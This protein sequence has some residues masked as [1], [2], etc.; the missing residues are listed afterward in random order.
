MFSVNFISIN[1][2]RT[3]SLGSHPLQV[4]FHPWQRCKQCGGVACWKIRSRTAWEPHGV[5]FVFGKKLGFGMFWDVLGPQ[6]LLSLSIIFG[7]PTVSFIFRRHVILRQEG[8]PLDNS[9][10]RLTDSRL[11]YGQEPRTLQAPLLGRSCWILLHQK[12]LTDHILPAQICTSAQTHKLCKSEVWTM[13]PDSVSSRF[14]SSCCDG[15]LR[16]LHVCFGK[17]DGSGTISST[18]ALARLAS[19]ADL[20]LWPLG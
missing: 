18:L 17:G 12:N 11:C 20:C 1:P 19:H 13:A 4:R 2:N 9:C 16:I 5:P 6:N 3:S 8:H 10:Y 14:I 15:Q 7:Y